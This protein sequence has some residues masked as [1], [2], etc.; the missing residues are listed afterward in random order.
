MKL[1][2]NNDSVQFWMYLER[3]VN[4]GSDHKFRH[5]SEIP[6][7]YRP[8]ALRASIP[9]YSL[10]SEYHKHEDVLPIDFF[11]VHPYTAELYRNMGHKVTKTKYRAVPTSSTRTVM[12]SNDNFASNYL[13]K[14]DLPFLI[15]RFDRSIVESDITFSKHIDEDLSQLKIKSNYSIGSFREVGGGHTLLTDGRHGGYI[16][17]DMEPTWFSKP[18]ENFYLVPSFALVSEDSKDRGSDRLLVQILRGSDNPIGTL[19]EKILKPL[20]DYWFALAERGLI[21]E[22]QQQNTL[23]VLDD[24][25]EPCG[26]V[27]RDYDGIYIDKAYRE[28]IGLKNKFNKHV[29]TDKAETFDHRFCK[30][31]ILRIITCCEQ[32]FDKKIAE[33]AKAEI[34]EYIK[35]RM[36]KH[37]KEVLPKDI[38]YTCP[39]IMFKDGIV[40]IPEKNPPLR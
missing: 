29:M 4:D 10:T 12:I 20:I 14:L 9:I 2:T 23:F 1:P 17:R 35:K 37:V 11:P 25:G 32:Y 13:V 28:K 38:W 6:L 34:K 33:A 31:N 24:K 30:Q 40:I 22:L 5:Q 7:K 3:Y 26:V 27:S 8:G 21:W 39:E 19:T 15:S 18:R 16:V 36:P